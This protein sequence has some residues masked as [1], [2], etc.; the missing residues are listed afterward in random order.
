MKEGLAL[1]AGAAD[2]AVPGVAAAL[3]ALRPPAAPP[4]MVA[5]PRL[6]D[7]L[8]R[9]LAASLVV[10][11][12]PAGWGK[13]SLLRDW[14][15][16]QDS[17][18]AW[19]SAGED[20]NDPVVFWSEV[21]AALGTVAP[22]T[23]AAALEALAGPGAGMPERAVTLL[24]EDLARLAGPVT[25]VVD[26]FDRVTSP[27]VLAGVGLLAEHLPPE[28]SV[29]V[30]GRRDP[31]LPLARLRAAGK[32]A[33]IRAGQLRFSEAEAEAML[34]RTLGLALPPEEVHALWQRTE[35][36]PAGL[37]L[38]G[39]PLRHHADGHPAADALAA[40]DR[41][42]FDYLSAE[43]LAGLPTRLRG[44]LLRTA[45]LD[46]FCAPLCDAVTG[47]AEAADLLEEVDRLQL[48]MVPLDGARGWYRYHV[49]FATALRRELE[50]AEPGLAPLLHRRAAA[51]HRQHG[52]AAVAVEHALASCDWSD[53]REMI[54]AHWQQFLDEGLAE[55]LAGWLDRLPL[56]VGDARM[57]IVAAV[58]ASLHGRPQE[59]E[60][61]LAAAETATP[62]GLWPDGPESVESA[63][64]LCRALNHWLKGDLAAADPASRRA[65][66]FELESGTAAWRART[67]AVLGAIL[68]WR[69]HDT[70]AAL[71]LEQVIGPEH[72]R[73]GN[74]ARQLAFSCLATISARHGD[75]EAAD[76]YA[77]QA[78]D[79]PDSCKVTVLADLTRAELLAGCGEEAE[80][81]TTALAALDQARQHQ[82]CLDTAAAL[83]CLAGICTRTGRPADARTH[84]DEASTLID[85]LPDSGILPGLLADAERLA[86][87][88]APP[89]APRTRARR[90]DGLTG[91]EAEVLDLLTSGHTNLEIA[92]KLV[93]SVH[94]VE[95]HLQNAY[96]KVG[97]RNR[98][99]AA[100]YMA[101]NAS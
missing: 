65:A 19:L 32:L 23:G 25:L 77:R 48:F 89:P 67:L 92:A 17:G 101:R 36:W 10:V 6:V 87:P 14:L 46:R 24:I 49:L 50:R 8:A 60:R 9:S 57:C 30:A 41:H 97:V 82:W 73:A 34:N 78:A 37:Y 3:A 100:A 44:F 71:L 51:W 86:N 39:L 43:V 47:A 98:A 95:R 40:G 52:T 18:V 15:A 5:R 26:D 69:G 62:Q 55:T 72:W 70:D 93:I 96:R 7:R 76:R 29:I 90:P 99:D 74:H 63:V 16:A 11:A 20:D 35:G 75:D 58:S 2:G 13:T 56:A 53:A 42:V 21:I 54:A 27:E 91:R 4:G 68:C 45:V 61:W 81:E 22:G 85:A 83:I 64:C 38:T 12:A 59:A 79:L 80:G 28:L 84:L 1:V 94:T 31:Q 33:E 88:P 66:E